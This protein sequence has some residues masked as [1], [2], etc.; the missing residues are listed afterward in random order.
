MLL[1]VAQTLLGKIQCTKNILRIIEKYVQLQQTIS[2]V[3][4]VL[5][6]SK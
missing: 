1:E 5:V 6:A 2:E 3:T 4:Q